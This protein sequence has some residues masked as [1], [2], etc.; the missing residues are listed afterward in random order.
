MRA[1]DRERATVE[2]AE[3]VVSERACAAQGGEGPSLE[4]LI[5]DTVY[6]EKKRLER[7]RP[8]KDRDRDLALYD[9]ACR[10]TA[11]GSEEERKRVL[12]EIVDRF[13]TEIVGYF[14]P[15]VYDVAT[16]VAP[17]ALALLLNALSPWRLLRELP[18][19][20]SFK[21]NV[22]IRGETERLR[23]LDDKGTIILTPTHSSN[24]DSIVIGWVLNRLGLPPF[25]Y[26]AGLNLFSNPLLS[27]FMRNLGAYRV[28]RKKTAPLYKECL[29]EYATV[30]IE[31]G[32]DNLFFPGGTRSR[33]GGVERKLKLGLLGCG[34]RAYVN[35]LKRRK[36]K[37]GIYVVPATI[38]YELT[39]EAETLIDDYLKEV[40]KARYIIEDDESSQI[41]RVA[42]FLTGILSLDARIYVTF[43]RALDPFGNEVESDGLSYDRR[44]RPVDTA[45]YVSK[46]G[47]PEHDAQR[48]A[49]YTRELGLSIR[50]AFHRDNIL[51]STHVVAF[52][53]F[54]LLTARNQGM[55][56][57][58]LLRGGGRED[59]L[60][61]GDLDQAVGRAIARI[62]EMS[63]R[64]EVRLDPRLRGLEADRIIADALWR[65]GT[66]HRHTA[67]KRVG[68][69]VVSPDR[70]LLYFYH[71]RATGYGLERAVLG[72]SAAEAEAV[73]GSG[74]ALAAAA[75]AAKPQ[76]G[77]AG[78][79]A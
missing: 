20:P 55:D 24:L 48:D 23:A 40:G 78:A 74:G 73:A 66:Y 52:T 41:R 58:R 28:D 13:V 53:A 37:P 45:S 5:L 1:E 7:E 49:E 54:T 61:L 22:T 72:L 77:L 10:R 31:L 76:P 35:N 50:A 14:D 46:G 6:E 57:Y 34:L 29:K 2:V 30:S 79:A 42:E 15:R 32:Y 26:G 60:P 43:S 38:S 3:R 16:R 71:N 69:R 39:L 59:S 67:L 18:A 33:S 63:D 64:D 8:S 51:Q 75:I 9:E 47:R 4:D 11:A 17:T 36:E 44:G 70:S 12:R 62:K 56:L 21:P 25:L 27:F 68:D 65:F 19:L